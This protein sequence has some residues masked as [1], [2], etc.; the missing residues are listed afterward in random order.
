MWIKMNVL[1]E[2]I[3]RSDLNTK[4]ADGF[5]CIDQLPRQQRQATS[6]ALPLQIKNMYS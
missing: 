2:E 1:P 6:A 4:T 5:D 3:P